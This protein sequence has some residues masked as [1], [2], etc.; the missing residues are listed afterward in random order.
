MISV[1]KI[2]AARPIVEP[3]GDETAR[4]EARDFLTSAR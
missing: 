3:D 1:A 4:I 2:E